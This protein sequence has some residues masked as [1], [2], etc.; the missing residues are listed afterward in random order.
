MFDFPILN[1]AIGLIF[2]FLLYSSL[3]STTIELIAS[4]LA[5]RAKGV[6]KALQRMLI[7]D[8]TIV[9]EVKTNI[10]RRIL[11]F[12]KRLWKW[13]SNP[14][15]SKK[16]YKIIRELYNTPLISSFSSGTNHKKPSYLN[17]ES[18]AKS[19]IFLLKKPLE[20]DHKDTNTATT[21]TTEK[22]DPT[23]NTEQAD[24][25]S[26]IENIKKNINNPNHPLFKNN[27][28]KLREL[29]HYFWEEIPGESDKERVHRFNKNIENWYNDT[30]DRAA[31]WYKKNT[32]VY[33]LFMGFILANAFQIN[34]IDIAQKL[35]SSTETQEEILALIPLYEKT[36]ISSDS[37][38]YDELVAKRNRVIKGIEAS[39]NVFM[40][41]EQFPDAIKI[42]RFSNTKAIQASMASYTIN[43][44]TNAIYTLPSSLSAAKIQANYKLEPAYKKE[45]ANKVN[46]QLHLNKFAFYYNSLKANFWGYLITAIAISLGGK[47][48]YEILNK[49]VNLKNSISPKDKSK[50]AS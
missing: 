26:T 23:T 38:S 32:T 8:E 6:E 14:L 46:Y 13:F 12:W 29:L 28:K 30:M 19:L 43:A 24:A 34:T 9:E 2:I 27:S 42:E 50:Q 47:F 1:V 15:R 37:L 16:E 11:D 40:I 10:L 39:N 7:D 41:E 44:N 49:I 5:L 4:L 35:Y 22:N 18:F 36:T 20:S 21:E 25:A 31:G 17:S 48:W 45:Q 33:L 3:A